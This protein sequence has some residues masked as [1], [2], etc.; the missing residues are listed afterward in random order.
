MPCWIAVANRRISAQWARTCL[1]RESGK[2]PVHRFCR[3]AMI[4]S[5]GHR[6]AS[7]RN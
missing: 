7:E 2:Q 3:D 4:S 5:Q 1:V 6:L